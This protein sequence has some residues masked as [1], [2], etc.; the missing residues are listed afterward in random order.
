LVYGFWDGER[1]SVLFDGG[2]SV[3]KPRKT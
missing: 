1:L 2:V 3:S